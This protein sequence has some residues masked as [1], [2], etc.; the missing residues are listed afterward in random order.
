MN[1]PLTWEIAHHIPGRVRLRHPAICRRPLPA[2]LMREFMSL[3]PGV[4]SV[5]IHIATGSVVIH[6]DQQRLTL[7]S[8][9][10]GLEQCLSGISSEA[11]VADFPDRAL[12]SKG[13]LVLTAALSE[14]VVPPLMPLSAAMLL[15]VGSDTL[16]KASRNLL[17]NEIGPETIE[18]VLILL[19]MRTGR[20]FSGA[21]M[22]LLLDFWPRFWADAMLRRETEF[23]AAS[24]QTPHG[25]CIATPKQPGNEAAPSDFSRKA[26]LPLLAL[27]GLAL[28][29]RGP[30][31]AQAVLRPDYDTGLTMIHRLSTL[32][33]MTA[34]ARKGIWI[35]REAVLEAL[36]KADVIIIHWD[37]GRGR[38]PL[39]ESIPS[40]TGS[41]M[42]LVTEGK[43]EPVRKAA[44]MIGAELYVAEAD[45]ATRI[46][47]I[48]Y[49]RQQGRTVCYMGD[50]DADATV[51]KQADLSVAF[52][53]GDLFPDE[54][55]AYDISCPDRL[56]LKDLIQAVEAHRERITA[57][58]SRLM[59]PNLAA[60]AGALF[61]GFPPLVSVL[62]SNLGILAAYLKLEVSDQP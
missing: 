50:K 58:K 48:R 18:S 34:L 4:T 35:R 2:R 1:K 49:F 62:L 11:F 17:A 30:V 61:A 39:R 3:F 54:S 9:L 59:L 42:I 37:G 47:V 40:L 56:S 46:A 29:T 33:T 10:D 14:F 32:Q 20:F 21:L 38:R 51:F 12:L 44:D 19:A 45:A 25:V 7:P 15:A 13:A 36:M 27:S 6:Y 22:T 24:G 8:L 5:Q 23:R 55:A 26:A 31:A 57:G 43:V 41:K 28:L 53:S 60:V 16:K 52:G